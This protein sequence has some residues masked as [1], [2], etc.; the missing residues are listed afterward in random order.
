MC[1]S[2][3]HCLFSS[4]HICCVLR[5]RA[6]IVLSAFASIYGPM[7][8]AYVRGCVES[9]SGTLITNNT[10]STVYNYASSIGDKVNRFSH[11]LLR[12]EAYAMG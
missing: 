6:V 12:M 1:A 8:K 10:Y 2:S 11:S 7:Y 5:S 3:C 4:V 9:D